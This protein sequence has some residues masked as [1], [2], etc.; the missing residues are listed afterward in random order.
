MKK[1]F[2][3]TWFKNNFSNIIVLLSFVVMSAFYY[4]SVLE[5]GPLNDHQWRQADCLSLAHH[6]AEGA[7][8]FKPEM[9]IQLGDD[10]TNGLTV[11]E[12]PILYFVVGNIW[13]IVGESY[14]AYRLF[15]LLI[16]LAGIWAFYRSLR[17]LFNDKFWSVF[18][19]LL[20]FTSPVYVIYGVSFL[21]DVPAFSF[22]LIALYFFLQF[23][24]QKSQKRLILSMAFFA[25][26]GLIKISSLIAF[27]FVILYLVYEQ[28]PLRWIQKNRLFNKPRGIF[29]GFIVVIL[30]IFSWYFYADYFNDIHRFKYTFNHIFPIWKMNGD[31][32]PHLFHGIVTF[33]SPILFSRTI[34][35]L[36][37]VLFI[38]NL[39]LMKRQHPM[40]WLSNIGVM[41]GSSAYFVLW[42]PLMGNH[43]YYFV[44]YLILLPGV[45]V[46]FILYLR[47]YQHQIFKSWIVKVGLLLLLAYNFIYCLN[48][49]KLKTLAEKGEFP[50]INNEELVGA[51]RWINW[52]VRVNWK[53]FERMRPYL[54]EI[55][56]E[57]DDLVISLPDKSFNVSLNL[58]GQK[59]WTDFMNY[60]SSEDIQNLIEHGAEF[61]IISDKQLLEAEF[62]QPFLS[63][64]IGWY[65][66]ILIFRLSENMSVFQEE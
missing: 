39:F 16:S 13:K 20:M 28:I 47:N 49:V 4:D 40:A 45:M 56:V 50:I 60:S 23:Q 64:S 41:V 14:F 31:Q 48:V 59:G 10:N 18:L 25:L 26:A 17:V 33:T 51:M 32:M 44:A 5:R 61:L 29:V 46:P 62:L 35:F 22:I 12:F 65:E 9:H 21:T 11:G 34:L 24:V 42:A 54:R 52:D 55:G 19:S 36:L 37:F 15:Y 63:D 3:T 57:K 38:A 2:P 30:L 27:V 1:S 66:D 53:R 6:F 7:S 8:F 58:M 43:E